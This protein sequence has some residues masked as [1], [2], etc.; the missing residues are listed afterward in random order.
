MNVKAHWS[1]EEN[2]WRVESHMQVSS[3]RITLHFDSWVGRMLGWL[4]LT[5]FELLASKLV[6]EH[7]HKIL[8]ISV[9][10]YSQNTYVA[11]ILEIIFGILII[12]W[13]LRACG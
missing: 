10:E 12:Y 2:V 9:N 5:D 7:A 11:I 3:D 8:D 13:F 1:E 4:Q 6:E